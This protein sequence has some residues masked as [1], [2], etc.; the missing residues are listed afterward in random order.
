MLSDE[1]N[2]VNKYFCFVPHS[3]MHEA[4]FLDEDLFTLE[5]EMMNEKNSS[6]KVSE[7]EVALAFLTSPFI[8]TRATTEIVP[9]TLHQIVILLK[10]LATCQ[11]QS[12]G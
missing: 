1:T 4:L 5:Q 8:R 7:F 11:M 6:N 3:P 2:D 12:Y 9:E 10:L